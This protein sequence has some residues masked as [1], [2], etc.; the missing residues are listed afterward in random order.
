MNDITSQSSPSFMTRFLI[1]I[2][3]I[4]L[5]A[6]F[7]PWLITVAFLTYN[8]MSIQWEYSLVSALLAIFCK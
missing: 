4:S 8:K 3:P 6:T 2:R 5:T 1:A 7:T